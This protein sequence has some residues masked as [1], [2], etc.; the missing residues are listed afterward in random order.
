MK[1]FIFDAKKATVFTKNMFG[2]LTPTQF[3]ELNNGDV[4]EGKIK[5]ADGKEIGFDIAKT[6]KVIIG[7]RT[8]E[9]LTVYP[10][11]VKTYA[12]WD[13][14]GL[15]MLYE[16]QDWENLPELFLVIETQ[17]DIQLVGFKIAKKENEVWKTET[18]PS[19]AELNRY[20]TIN[21]DDEV[22]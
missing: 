5:M 21:L 8:P 7:F 16:I 2:V 6:D 13:K 22:L 1:K 18:S 12:L 10:F 11:Q 19:Y 9:N 15:E 17:N 4:M 3:A 14:D 20:T